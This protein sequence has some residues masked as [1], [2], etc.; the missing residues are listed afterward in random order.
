MKAD[1]EFHAILA[2]ATGNRFL[3]LVLAPILGL[4]ILVWNLRNGWVTFLH[5][6]RLAGL[7][8]GPAVHWEGP[9][10]FVG[11]QFALLLGFWFVAWRIAVVTGAPLPPACWNT[12][13]TGPT[14]YTHQVVRTPLPYGSPSAPACVICERIFA[15]TTG[16]SNAGTVIDSVPA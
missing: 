14:P 4:P 11:V 3:P 1:S 6:S 7:H 10:V 16:M 9:L 15:A 5:V 8:S 12:T 2:E 13:F